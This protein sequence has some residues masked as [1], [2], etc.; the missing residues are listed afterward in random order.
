[1]TLEPAPAPAERHELL[2]RDRPGGAEERV[3]ERRGVALAEDQVIIGR[4]PR[5][6]PV[7]AQV[8][9]QEDGH[10]IGGRQ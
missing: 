9:D 7:V 1:M 5:L 10:Q 6:G 3:V 2:V 4:I 8:P